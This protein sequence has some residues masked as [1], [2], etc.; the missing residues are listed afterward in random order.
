MESNKKLPLSV[1]ISNDDVIVVV[2]G[3]ATMKISHILK[4]FVMDLI[5][6]SIGRERNFKIDLKNCSYMDSTFTGILIILEKYAKKKLNNRFEILNP[7]NFC[8]NVL[9]TMG[10]VPLFK[11]SKS[12]SNY[13]GKTIVLK[14][15]H[16]EKLEE[17]ILMYLAHKEL[18]NVS[19][20]NKEEFKDVQKFLTEHIESETGK[21]ID[22]IDAESFLKFQDKTFNDDDFDLDFESEDEVINKNKD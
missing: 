1:T 3:D 18:S 19:N 12:N 14:P 22:E 6:E 9:D 20:D 7:S 11:I 10:L 8:F 5:D 21:D 16:I 2:N 4:K 15:F 17:A 13:E